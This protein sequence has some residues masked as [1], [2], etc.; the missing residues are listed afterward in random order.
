[1]TTL[2]K[3]LDS[4]QINR[5]SSNHWTFFKLLDFLDISRS[6]NHFL[7]K[8][9]IL[10]YLRFKRIVVEDGDPPETAATLPGNMLHDLL[11][12]GVAL[13]ATD[14]NIMRLFHALPFLTQCR[15]LQR[16]L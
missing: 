4:L 3:V 15:H 13:G 10:G 16:Y 1:M 9:I 14:V 12:N 6:S 7:S 8:N 2:L 11:K 5:L